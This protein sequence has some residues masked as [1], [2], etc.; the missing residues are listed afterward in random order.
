MEAAVKKYIILFLLST[1]FSCNKKIDDDTTIKIA[2]EVK[3]IE[4]QFISE[5]TIKEVNDSE[6]KYNFIFNAID[7]RNINNEEVLD[8]VLNNKIKSIR[9]EL[10][11]TNAGIEQ[12]IYS[13]S[14][15]LNIM[16]FDENK[17]GIETHKG[18]MSHKSIMPLNTIAYNYEMKFIVG[19]SKND[20]YKIGRE[21]KMLNLEDFN[22]L[23][24]N[25][26]QNSN[27]YPE[28]YDKYMLSLD[29]IVYN[30]T[31]KKY[32]DKNVKIQF[33]LNIEY[34]TKE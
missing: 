4:K 33:R 21:Y 28:E 27:L 24:P 17:F 5:L 31:V 2:K 23:I 30:G 19:H 16:Y 26:Y 25:E 20:V 6:V 10:Y 7:N 29:D 3:I 12:S 1:L 34:F 11:K 22:I 9:L 32:L 18:E 8:A 13:E 15:P 14:L